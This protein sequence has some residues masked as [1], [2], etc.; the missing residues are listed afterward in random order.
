MLDRVA[1]SAFVRRLR[2]NDIPAGVASVT[3]RERDVVVF[4]EEGGR[5]YIRKEWFDA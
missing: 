1:I 2:E 4:W 3:W 5:T